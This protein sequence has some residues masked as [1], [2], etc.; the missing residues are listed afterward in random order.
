MESRE[1]GGDPPADM[2]E[3]GEAG[4]AELKRM[5]APRRHARIHRTAGGMPDADEAARQALHH[6]AHMLEKRRPW[7]WLPRWRKPR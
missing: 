4:A 6:M 3:Q 7:W 5:G 1:T 2:A